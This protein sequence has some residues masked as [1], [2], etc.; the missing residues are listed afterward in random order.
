MVAT[1]NGLSGSCGGG[2]ITALAGSGSVGLAGATLAAGASCTFSVNVTA[3]TPGAKTNTTSA[4]TSTNGGTGGTASATLS[5]ALDPDLTIAKSHAGTFQRGQ[6]GTWTVSVANAGRTPTFGQVT[7]VDTLPA[8][9]VALGVDAQGWACATV[10]ARVTCTRANSLATGAAYP[11][12]NI[13]IRPSLF[14]LPAVTN[15]AWVSGGGD[16]DL[17]VQNLAWETATVAR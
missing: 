5:V 7:V 16:T 14:A 3:T 1:P 6:T 9:I 8:G 2:T 10:V 12:I 15:F 13:R 17:R 4:V 11:P